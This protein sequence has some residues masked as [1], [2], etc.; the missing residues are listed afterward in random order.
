MKKSIIKI[1]LLLFSF[2]ATA[3]QLA[4]S[5]IAI[6]EPPVSTLEVNTTFG[7]QMATMF[8][9]LEKNRVPHGLLLDLAMEFTNVP[10]FNG[11]LTDSTFV[12]P[13]TLKEIYNTL[14]M[15]RIRDVT[16]G[17]VTPD[18]FENN[19][20]AQRAEE[21]IALSGLYFKY[22][23]F[24]LNAATTNKLTYTNG[25]IYDKYIGSVWQNPYQEMKT[26]A[27][28]SPVDVY[29]GLNLKIKIPQSIFYSN[30][31]NEIQNIAID[32][33]DGLGFRLVS[34]NQLVNVNY[35]L[36]GVKTWK[37]RLTL[38][39][40]QTML[41][42]SKI[43]IKKELRIT[44][45]TA[46]G[47]EL[48]RTANTI[49]WNNCSPT[50]TDLYRLDIQSIG[51][52][53]GFS[54]KA[55]VFIDD[56]GNDC[57]I[58]KPLIVVEGFDLTTIIS[59]ETRFSSD[60]YINFT[61]SVFFSGS[62]SLKDLISGSSATING[63]QQYDIIYV[64]WDNGMDYIERN[65][66]VVE[67][68]IKWVNAQ[69]TIAGSTEKNVLMGQSMGGIV[70]RYALLN[71]EQKIPAVIHQVR[72][73]VSQDSPQQGA[74]LPLSIQY[75]FN[76]IK[77]QVIQAPAYWLFN[78][79]SQVSQSLSLAGIS[80]NP[81]NNPLPVF[82]SLLDRPAVAQMLINRSNGNYIINN[83][84]HE[85]FYSTLN[86]RG[87]PTQDNIR[88]VAI[89]NGNECGKTQNF[90]Q[91]DVL[92]SYSGTKK[93]SFLQN[94]LAP[95]AAAFG[96]ALIDTDL[97]AVTALSLLPGGSRFDAFL[98]DRALY[99]TGGNKIHDLNISYTKWVL[100][101]W[102][103]KVYIIDKQLYQPLS[104]NK[105]FDNYG[106]GFID[107][108]SYSGI[109]NVAGLYVR[110][111]FC[112]VPTPSALSINATV[113]SDFEHSYIGGAPP[114]S[115]LN[116][117]FINYTTAFKSVSNLNNNNE[118]HLEFNS[119]NGN[120]L[121]AELENKSENNNCSFLCNS[122][123]SIL[124]TSLI[125][126]NSN[127]TFIAPEGAAYY[128]WSIE[129][130]GSSLVI[131]S[132]TNSQIVSL[133]TLDGAGG[134]FKIKVLI[135]G[136][137]TTTYANLQSC[138]Y[139]EKTILIGPPATIL[140]NPIVG[141]Y[142][143]VSIGSASA[144]SIVPSFEASS[145]QWEVKPILLNDDS[146]PNC[147]PPTIIG[148]GLSANVFWG[149]CTGKFEVSVH[150]VNHCGT[151]SIAYKIVNVFRNSSGGGGNNG[152]GGNPCLTAIV[153]IYP[154]PVKED[155]IVLSVIYPPCDNPDPDAK[156]PISN[157]VNIY[158]LQGNLVFSG[159]Y[160]T[161]DIII[162]RLYLEKN[163]YV[164]NVTT[165]T[166]QVIQTVLIVE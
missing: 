34:Y 110:D 90:D 155:I 118:K 2:C 113:D 50:T 121:A 61:K 16:T 33:G 142:D 96:G 75:L 60:D 42:H 41:S 117:P 20:F 6:P 4:S 120:W 53:L 109:I 127:T 77:N 116:S 43:K 27:I 63:D 111:K 112:L 78:G 149:T 165:E 146:L 150:A 36:E 74:S 147:Q 107:I 122:N 99:Q 123:Q 81:I 22:S 163:H 25:I 79:V 69:K 46:S 136:V 68:V 1:S 144:F 148:S 14:L 38:T 35:T 56:A 9:A 104:I 72:L 115:P 124:G 82:G 18:E 92:I 58:T 135:S 7:Q 39:N 125:C 83:I 141:G 24:A 15:S 17:F 54:G 45:V 140:S 139:L 130:V 153:E 137:S 44:N 49:T 154:N 80:I 40:G 162:D 59:P 65:A 95:F 93:L 97:F 19:W 52:F 76:N 103:Q 37:Y 84:V 57:K 151:H 5:A 158:N 87:F 85:K 48:F 55:R 67:E 66:L 94:I 88:N 143:N 134:V 29:K 101:I 157:S 89:S 105:H 138:G 129:G 13:K 71:M 161:S 102:K 91:G 10:A 132:N 98:E 119:R 106:G 64:N 86:S 32:F 160:Q 47:G 100:G 21:H 28:A 152:G 8:G 108:G 145:Y 51:T 114:A 164:L 26:F 128:E 23:R 159:K 12:R 126:D 156:L 11:T 166:G 133:T 131:L 30:Y 62:N 3:Q 70:C 31:A 73:F